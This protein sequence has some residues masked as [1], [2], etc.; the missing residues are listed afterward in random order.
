MSDKTVRNRLNEMGFKYR[1]IKHKS[2]PTV[3]HKTAMG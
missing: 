2:A 3:K 1:K